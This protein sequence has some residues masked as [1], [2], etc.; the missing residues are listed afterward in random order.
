MTANPSTSSSYDEDSDVKNSSTKKKKKK[1]TKKEEKK[2][3]ADSGHGQSLRI[4]WDGKKKKCPTEH[5]YDCERL[6]VDYK[7]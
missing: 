3:L 4:G 6:L 1:R 2:N 5:L 7:N